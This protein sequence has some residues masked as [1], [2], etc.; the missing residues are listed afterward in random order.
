MQLSIDV[1]AEGISQRIKDGVGS[2]FSF[3]KIP[4]IQ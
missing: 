1:Q 4:Q 3:M 2:S